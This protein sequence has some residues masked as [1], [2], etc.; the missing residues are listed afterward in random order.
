MDLENLFKLVLNNPTNISIEYSNING[1]EKLL[2]N[3]KDLTEKK[4]KTFDDSAIKTEIKLYKENISYLDEWVW[5]LVIDEAN[6]RYFN[7]KEMDRILSLDSYTE[8]EAAQ[9]HNTIEIMK[10]LINETLK[11]EV[12]SLVD[13][14][15]RF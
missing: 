9:A 13:L 1:K 12:Q 3:G 4:D 10:D 15:E 5:N 11:Q 6:N 8:E 14:M 2:V 7:L